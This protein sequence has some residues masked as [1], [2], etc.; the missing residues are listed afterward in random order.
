MCN[1]GGAH[2]G[3]ACFRNEGRVP[4]HI[5]VEVTHVELV[6][7]DPHAEELFA[8]ARSTPD[9]AGASAGLVGRIAAVPANRRLQSSGQPRAWTAACRVVDPSGL[10]IWRYTPPL[11]KPL[12]SSSASMSTHASATLDGGVGKVTVAP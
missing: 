5:H 12:F 11:A 1:A 9:M 8:G 7:I 6:E 4:R 10:M 3:A 2:D